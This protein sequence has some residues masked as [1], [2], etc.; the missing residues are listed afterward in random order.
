MRQDTKVHDGD[1][2]GERQNSKG[3]P[4][5]LQFPHQDFPQSHEDGPE[6]CVITISAWKNFGFVAT[7]YDSIVENSPES[8]NC[9]VW[10]VCDASVSVHDENREKIEKIKKFAGK[11]LTIVTMTDLH[12]TFGKTLDHSGL[13]FTHSMTDLQKILK[14]FVFQYAFEKLGAG[15]AIYLDSDIWV[16][17]PLQ[18]VQETLR[19]HSVVVTPQ[20]LPQSLKDGINPTEFETLIAGV[21]NFG[22][23]GFK[24]SRQGK[25][26][27]RFWGESLRLYGY[28]DWGSFIPIFFSN[29]DY[30]VLKDPSYINDCGNLHERGSSLY[31]SKNGFP[32]VGESQAKIVHFSGLSLLS[33][34]ELRTISDY[35]TRYNHCRLAMEA[36]AMKLKENRLMSFRSIPYG[37]SLFSDGTVIDHSMR[38]AYTAAMSPTP[39]DTDGLIEVFY[40]KRE[41]KLH[42]F[43]VYP[44]DRYFFQ[45]NVNHRNPFCVSTSCIAE[46]EDK[47]EDITFRDWYFQYLSKYTVFSEGAFFYS[48]FEDALWK[49]SRRAKMAYPDPAGDDFVNFK[50]WILANRNNRK[51]ISEESFNNWLMLWEHHFTHHTTYHKN[52]NK[53][54][55]VGVNVF[56]W[57][58]GLFSVGMIADKVTAV[59][60]KAL[61]P[62]R[63]IQLHPC[64]DKKFV[65]PQYL[66]QMP[67]R[68]PLEIV[69][70]VAVTA[71]FCDIVKHQV[72]PLVWK[73]KY[74]IGYWAWELDTFPDEWVHHLK[75]F[76]EI[77]CLTSFI[78]E[79]L[80]SS[81][82]YDRYKIPIKVLHLPLSP[83]RSLA[84]Q[85][86][87]S[88]PFEIDNLKDEN[89]NAPF[90]FLVVFDFRSFVKRKNPE[91]AIRAFLDAFPRDSL[92]HR[93]IIKS[94][95]GTPE[96]VEVLEK[97]A[98]KDPRVIFIS[99]MLSDAENTA[100]HNIQDC[101]VSLHR[102]EGYGL[103]I[104]ESMAA[105]KPVIA[106]NYSGNV[107]FFEAMDTIPE[108]LET[109]IF[110]VPYKL[111][112][113]KEND[114]FT[115]DGYHW[116]D[117]N[118]DYA[119]KAMRIAAQ[120]KCTEPLSEAMSKQVYNHFS[121][122]AVGKM[123]KELLIESF[124]RILWKQ[125]NNFTNIENLSPNIMEHNFTKI[126]NVSSNIMEVSKDGLLAQ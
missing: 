104:L 57:H 97:A 10:F 63:L 77:W 74:N 19:T 124:P 39:V 93:L 76:D 64:C 85:H 43:Q 70:L 47:R 23:V 67:T 99:R 72:P 44:H 109:C 58:G 113:L 106:T 94:H 91:A 16:T 36:Y 56:G 18:E 110:P 48:A 21:F 53:V 13:F 60:K 5:S 22:F 108:V 17:G 119:V 98:R 65:H 103:N 12:E 9:F 30:M 55:D 14:P 7:L 45:N 15:A 33:D 100:L 24:N 37:Y 35:Q 29:E 2:M 90:I 126:E 125:Q 11:V 38:E 92:R 26:F 105:G 71:N 116:A 28:Q 46:M 86:D 88:L 121:E 114:Y 68:T 79:S 27:V 96:E 4:E 120:M 66:A 52:I 1:G 62:T 122:A 54:D 50:E 87:V 78:K 123:M 75:D 73:N 102:S 81:P 82:I 118:H 34:Y 101:Y 107:A 49:R 31:L 80:Q 112:D 83:V 89:G 95:S 69:N 40:N 59:A 20:I 61:I 3:G 41:M 6:V 32:F 8:S 117:P 115:I 51:Y 84:E 111:I 25:D 42:G